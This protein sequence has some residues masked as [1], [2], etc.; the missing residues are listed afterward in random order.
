MAQIPEPMGL[1]WPP[2]I[3]GTDRSRERP[4]CLACL[5]EDVCGLERNVLQFGEPP[6]AEEAGQAGDRVK[7]NCHGSALQQTR[8]KYVGSKREP[9]ANLDIGGERPSN[10]G[11]PDLRYDRNARSSGR[12]GAVPCLVW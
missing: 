5:L 12:P 11:H 7:S 4:W 2:T 10:A 3:A 6:R 1:T 9:E 8:E